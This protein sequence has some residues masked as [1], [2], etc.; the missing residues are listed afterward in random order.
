MLHVAKKPA[1]GSLLRAQL[2]LFEQ[3]AREAGLTTR[4]CAAAL[5]LDEADWIRLRDTRCMEALPVSA[6]PDLLWRLGRAT[7]LIA[8]ADRQSTSRQSGTAAGLTQRPARFH[9]VT[10]HALDAI[11]PA[12]G[13]PAG[14]TACSCP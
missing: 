4:E 8:G 10:P 7:F 3:A 5:A 13:E 9:D 1:T 2:T 6:I 14:K 11:V 12:Q